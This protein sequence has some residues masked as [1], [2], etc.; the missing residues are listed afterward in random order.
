MHGYH[1][2]LRQGGGYV[3]QE[4]LGEQDL[5]GAHRIRGVYYDDVPDL[6]LLDLSGPIRY[7][8]LHIGMIQITPRREVL[9]GH[10]HDLTVYLRHRYPPRGVSEYLPDAPAV[11]SPYEEDFLRPLGREHGGM[12]QSLV[13][14][15]LVPLRHHDEAV[16]YEDDP[17]ELVPEYQDVLIGGP[18]RV[19]DLVHPEVEAAS[20]GVLFLEL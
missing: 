13:V 17:P 2:T 5:R 18:S 8:H 20:G 16:K 19:E 7:L 10:L 1:P 3:P 6:P 14:E 4:L 11:S 15:V 12:H 9:S